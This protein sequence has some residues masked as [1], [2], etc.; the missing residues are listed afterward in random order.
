MQITGTLNITCV[1]PILPFR[2][3]DTDWAIRKPHNDWTPVN[4]IIEPVT[5]ALLTRC[6]N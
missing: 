3:I 6:S 4:L 2:K 1:I 5:F